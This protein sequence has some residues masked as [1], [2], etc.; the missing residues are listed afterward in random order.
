MNP[1]GGSKVSKDKNFANNLE[2]LV[3]WPNG[4]FNLGL[5]GRSY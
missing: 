4:K 3:L 2:Y 5:P 1:G